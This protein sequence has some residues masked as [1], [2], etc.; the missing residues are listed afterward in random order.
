[1]SSKYLSQTSVPIESIDLRCHDLHCKDLTVDGSLNID[2]FGDISVNDIQIAR[3]IIYDRVAGSE[4][5]NIFRQTVSPSGDIVAHGAYAGT[6]YTVGSADGFNLAPF[7]SYV[8]SVCM[9]TL[10][11]TNDIIILGQPGALGSKLTGDGFPAARISDI[12]GSGFTL[13]IMNID[14]SAALSPASGVWIPF[15][16]LKV[17]A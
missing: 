10:D 15:Q 7:T 8:M 1:M 6:L 3:E 13:E 5:G 4:P 14:G 11:V 17:P 16:I 12:P 9:D 2:S